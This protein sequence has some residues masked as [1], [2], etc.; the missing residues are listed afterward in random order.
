MTSHRPSDVCLFPQMLPYICDRFRPLPNG[1]RHQV[2]RRSGSAISWAVHWICCVCGGE[3]FRARYIQSCPSVWKGLCPFILG[4]SLGVLDPCPGRNGCS[5]TL[6]AHFCR[7]GRRPCAE[8]LACLSIK[9]VRFTYHAHERAWNW[10]PHRV[11]DMQHC[12]LC[13]SPLLYAS[14][15]STTCRSL[16][17]VA[18]S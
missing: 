17:R 15:R 10:C 9:T 3:H 8:Q 13:S 11:W 2:G 6:R 1:G 14:P 4:V 7:P 5:L 18:R 12:V 16:I